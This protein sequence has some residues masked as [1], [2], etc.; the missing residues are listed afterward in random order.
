MIKVLRNVPPLIY[1]LAAR[2]D[3]PIGA[4]VLAFYGCKEHQVKR[5]GVTLILTA[6]GACCL[7]FG[8]DSTILAPNVLNIV[9]GE[10]HSIQALN[11]AGQPVTGLTW[12]SSDPTVVSLSTDDPPVLTALAA[13]TVTITAGTATA[14]VTVSA[15]ALPVGTV[16]WSNPGNG[17]GVYSIV[18][19]IPSPVGV[20]DVFAFQGDGTVLA[21]TSDGTTAW[22]ADVSNAWSVLPDFQGGLIAYYG[23]WSSPSIAKLD[24]NTG[25]VVA[26]YTLAPD[27]YFASGLGIHP[28][29]TIFAAL[30]TDDPS[31]LTAPQYSVVGI[32]SATGAQ[33]FSVPLPHPEE[34]FAQPRVLG[35]IVAGDGYAYVPYATR[36]LEGGLESNHLV[37]LR[38]S[39]DGA[40]EQGSIYDWTSQIGDFVPIGEV[41][42]IT[43]ADTGILLTWGS[44]SILYGDG[45]KDY[46]VY[47]TITTGV[48]AG[49]VL[50][51]ALPGN[52]EALDP[53]LQAQ[54][55]SFVGRVR[56]MD[57]WDW[58]MIAFDQSGS[59]RWSVAGEQP[60]I[61]TDDGGVIAQSGNI[62][63]LSGSATGQTT[64]LL[65]QSW[66][67]NL[68]QLGSVERVV[69]TP[70]AMAMSLWANAGANPSGNNTAARPWYFKLVWQNN[71]STV[72]WPCGF[73]LA[74]DNP[75]AIANLT[76]DATSQ[77][78]AIKQAALNA[79]KKA[80]DKYPVNASEGRP[81]S[82]D[83]RVNV[84]DGYNLAHPC[85]QSDNTPGKTVS[86]VFY[87]YNMQ[88]AQWALPIELTTA[89]D[90][91][92]AL[93]NRSLMKAIGSGI[94]NNAAHEM[95]HQFLLGA[96]GMDD[97]STNTYNGL[98]C[99]G[100][101]AAWVYGIGPIQWEEVTATALKNALGAGHK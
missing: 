80:F 47:M 1:Y 36:Q 55:G 40:A 87:G 73:N 42:M 67:G 18:P 25:A 56:D 57:T 54:D 19:A 45:P 83:H 43:N 89:Q 32:D 69:G 50:T 96:S 58:S 29:G 85:G 88:Q 72:P 20:A 39:S 79:F 51:P 101:T 97:S 41:K 5:S 90:V 91:T 68:Y 94:G 11:P 46:K 37:L 7:G 99:E 63:D 61:A 93:N 24:G 22:T 53:V 38:V 71:C 86:E 52:P 31:G 17:S 75:Q 92:N 76:I 33:K 100:D 8:Q 34:M 98:A 23:S 62:Y 48:S 14:Q 65:T 60:W 15:S 2:G 78:T 28:D 27:S 30:E 16:I 44:Q 13:G 95:A 6:L 82:G 49:A 21:I 35:L 81:D 3:R 9:V 74:P 64:D 10:T 66:R 70:T 26:A 4:V 12:T 84:I 77:A 59:V